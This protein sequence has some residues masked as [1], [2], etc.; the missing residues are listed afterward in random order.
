MNTILIVATLVGI[1][2]A[3]MIMFC[4]FRLVGFSLTY[5]LLLVPALAVALL[6][7]ASRYLLYTVLKA[8]FGAHIVMSVVSLF[9]VSYLWFKLPALLAAIAVVLGYML[10]ALGTLMIFL[11]MPDSEPSE[12]T[13]ILKLMILEETPL[14]LATLAIWKTKFS[15]IPKRV[16]QHLIG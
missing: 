15:I 1:V 6:V 5:R 13:T 12:F 4:G 10:L 3:Y 8:P 9:L 2:E 11:L 7:R 14:I 16:A